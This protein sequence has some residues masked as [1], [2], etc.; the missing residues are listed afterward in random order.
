MGSLNIKPFGKELLLDCYDCDYKSVDDLE[1]VYEFLEEAV[2]VLGVQKQTPPFVFHSP[3][4]FPDKAGISAWVP[5][6]ESGIQCHTLTAKNFISIDFYT[7]GELTP[8]MRNVLKELVTL[9]FS[10]E[11]IDS[12]FIL[13]GVEYYKE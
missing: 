13:R 4:E 3:P 2:L 9:C 5:L 1:S 8:K 12:Q 11:K 10:P 7:C 6:I